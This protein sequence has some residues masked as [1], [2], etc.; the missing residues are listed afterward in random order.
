M[1]N[2][3][4]IWF[5]YFFLPLGGGDKGERVDLEGIES[6]CDQGELHEISK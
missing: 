4:R 2:T 5:I 1:G 3:N 6:K